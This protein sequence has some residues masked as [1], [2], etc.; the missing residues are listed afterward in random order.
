MAGIDTGEFVGTDLSLPG[1][2][3]KLKA[4]GWAYFREPGLNAVIEVVLKTWSRFDF[5]ENIFSD[6]AQQRREL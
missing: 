2:E 6:T 3:A 1:S 4:L 5:G